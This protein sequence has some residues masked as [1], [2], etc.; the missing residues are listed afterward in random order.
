MDV[1]EEI[2]RRIDLAEYIGRAV[3][4]QK[5][6]R[7]FKGNCPFHAEKTPSFYVFPD[8]GTWRCFGAC[9]E[10]GD[11]F[12][13]VQKREGVDFRTALRELAREAGVQLSTGDPARRSRLDHLSALVSAAVE[14]YQRQ[15]REG[16]GAAAREYVFEKRGLSEESVAAFRIGWAPG[17]WRVLRDHLGARGYSEADAVAAGLLIEPESGGTPYDRFRGRVIIPIA[18]E[19]GRYVGLGGRALGDE[20][21]KYLNSPQTELFDKGR[22]L[23][24]LDLAAPGIRESG[25]VVVVEGYMD[26]IGPWQAGFRNVVATMGTSLTE[27][28]VALVRRLARRIVLALDPDAA[29]MRAAERAGGLLLGLGSPEEAARSARSAQDLAASAAGEIELRV[30]PLP[31]G[32]DP[33]EVAR[34]DPEGWARA[35]AEAPPFAEFLIGR[36]MEQDATGSPLEARQAIDRVRPVLLAVRDPV[37]RAMYVQRVARHLGVSEQAVQERVAVRQRPARPGVAAETAAPPREATQEAFLLATLLRYP[38]LRRRFGTLI[39]PQFFT[40]ALDREVFLRWKEQDN[41]SAGDETD[42]VAART[43]ELAG[44]PLPP[45]TVEKAAEDVRVKL[46]RIK[47]ERD[48]A[49]LAAMAERMAEVER[50]SGPATVAGIANRAWRGILADPSDREIAEIVLEVQQLSESMHRH[51]E[52][53]GRT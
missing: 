41:D 25:T 14:F 47:R 12:T 52:P 44:L 21:P 33:D 30:A 9:S 24:G 48:V 2:K 31:A 23:Y 51:E 34:D 19:R 5:S 17:E 43:R 26:V 28:H 46:D 10:G 35:I 4:L 53:T 15:F 37:E 13:F 40:D 22:T 20:Q 11:L 29:G 1:V 3:P 6:G 8:R 18:D 7:N 27:H 50:E 39:P 32:R 16:G 38:E 42:P 45:F 49:H 36:L